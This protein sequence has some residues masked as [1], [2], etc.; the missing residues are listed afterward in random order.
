[1][2][3]AEPLEHFLSG[4][5]TIYEIMGLQ[6]FSLSSVSLQDGFLQEDRV[7]KKHKFLILITVTALLVQI[8]GIG[9]AIWLE[10]QNQQND[11]V[12]TGLIVQFTAYSMMVFVV[13]VSILHSFAMTKQTKKI[14]RNF[15]KT[16]KIFAVELDEKIDD[17]NLARRIKLSFI[18][19]SSCFVVL[20]VLLLAFIYQH[21][22]TNV[23]LWAVLVIFP[24]FFLNVVDNYFMFFIMIVN[25][26]LKTIAK[27][28]A[29]FQKMRETK[30]LSIVTTHLYVKTE[31]RSYDETFNSLLKL[32]RIYGIIADTTSLI[33][34]V[35]GLPF[36]LKLVLM[37]LGNVSAGYKIYLA[38]M[39]D[40][41]VERIGGEVELVTSAQ[42][43]NFLPQFQFQSTQS[44]PLLEFFA[45]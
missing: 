7:S 41:P 30:K 5:T 25:E 22:Q 2:I 44:F 39:G 27:V 23:F 8:T 9:S 18:R 16:S 10:K 28:L 17:A 6:F 45:C 4:M 29:K 1:M 36:M 3:K 26:N 32:K 12:T 15:M 42:I 37:I 11:N 19:V 14:F 20:T 34:K 38:L 35:M 21:N 31:R 43:L 40:V 24:H 33:N 13:A